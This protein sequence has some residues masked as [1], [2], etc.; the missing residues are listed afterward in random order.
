M[1]KAEQAQVVEQRPTRATRQRVGGGRAEKAPPTRATRNRAG[2]P[3]PC[4]V[5]AANMR[6][7]AKAFPNV[8]FMP[9][10]MLV[11]AP[12]SRAAT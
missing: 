10:A 5:R 12:P 7:S 8:V 4:M 2:R 6:C 1:L 3:T 9:T 11:A